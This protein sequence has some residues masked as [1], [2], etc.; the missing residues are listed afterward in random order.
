MERRYEVIFVLVLPISDERKTRRH[1]QHFKAIHSL[2]NHLPITCFTFSGMWYHDVTVITF[3]WTLFL[4]AF[5]ML[6]L[7][8]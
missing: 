4:I 7:H 1:R 8:N 3:F 6:I 5:S 2:P